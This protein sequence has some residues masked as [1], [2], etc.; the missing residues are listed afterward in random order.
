MKA[1]CI[2]PLIAIGLA[3]IALA[4]CSIHVNKRN[5]NKEMK[6]KTFE[7]KDFNKISINCSADVKY[8]VS[9]TVNI[10]VNATDDWME[11]LDI[12]TADDGTLVIS[13]KEDNSGVIHLNTYSGDCQIIISGPSLESVV[14]AGSG[15]FKCWGGIQAD[16]FVGSVSGSGDM[17]IKSIMAENAIFTTVGSGDLIIGGIEAKK[18]DVSVS[19]SGDASVHAHKV[20]DINASVVGSGDITLDCKDC[21]TATAS[22]SGSGDISLFGN[23]KQLNQSTAGS[24]EI[25]ISK[26]KIGE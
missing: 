13:K 5:D 23:L 7:A 4:S 21:G 6:S 18:I 9:D 11:T 12:S 8:T 10:I 17:E 26:L 16:T 24:G 2:F 25:N 14:I 19:G 1:K 22:V 15:S 3:V 20:A